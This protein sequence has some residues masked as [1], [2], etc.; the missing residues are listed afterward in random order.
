MCGIE[1]QIFSSDAT[2][3]FLCA[4]LFVDYA[5]SKTLGVTFVE[6]THNYKKNV[7]KRLR[8][9]MYWPRKGTG[10]LEAHKRSSFSY[11]FSPQKLEVKPQLCINIIINNE[12]QYLGW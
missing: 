11:S 3:Q 4:G 9:A 1:G 8:K 2:L 10:H 12:I 5:M 7:E 6:P